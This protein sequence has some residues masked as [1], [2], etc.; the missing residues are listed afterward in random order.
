MYFKTFTKIRKILFRI[1]EFSKIILNSL[2]KY[3]ARLHLISIGLAVGKFH[4]YFSFVFFMCGGGR[5]VKIASDKK[6][7]YLVLYVQ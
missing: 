6:N 2:E 1:S 7:D 4:G 5:G 3:T